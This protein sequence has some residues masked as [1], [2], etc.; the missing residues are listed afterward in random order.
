MPE[1]Y[2]DEHKIY[3][4]IQALFYLIIRIMAG[5]KRQADKVSSHTGKKDGIF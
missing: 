3:K 4:R 5:C 1:R 2:P